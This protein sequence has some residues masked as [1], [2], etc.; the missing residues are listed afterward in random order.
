M[1][2]ALW[3]VVFSWRCEQVAERVSD[4]R[5]LEQAGGEL[6]QQRLEGVVVVPVDEHD[7]GV[8]VLQ[9]LRGADPGEPAA[10]DQDA[11]PSGG[12]A[13]DGAIPQRR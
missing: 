2:L 7:V 3:I 8:R 10:E 5:R 9:L 12:G 11:R 6:V 4:G 13:H 1:T